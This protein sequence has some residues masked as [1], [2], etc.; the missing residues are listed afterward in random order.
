M[1]RGCF[2]KEFF[3]SEVFQALLSPMNASLPCLSE[4]NRNNLCLHV[5]VDELSAIIL[6]FLDRMSALSKSQKC[7]RTREEDGLMANLL[8]LGRQR[9]SLGYR[10]M[11][12]CSAAA[13]MNGFRR[14]FSLAGPPRVYPKTLHGRVTV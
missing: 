10:V 4:G 6:L 8:L 1:R 7:Q 14:L 12:K 3:R 5:Y 13:Q 11:R 9:F 2:E